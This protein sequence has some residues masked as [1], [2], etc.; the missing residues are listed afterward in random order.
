MS[1]ISQ[2]AKFLGNSDA[3]QPFIKSYTTQRANDLSY[4]NQSQIDKL[5]RDPI[6]VARAKAQMDRENIDYYNSLQQYGESTTGLLS[7]E[8]TFD[9]NN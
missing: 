5:E 2:R 6:A 8:P 1:Y 9:P 3:V 4:M 7:M